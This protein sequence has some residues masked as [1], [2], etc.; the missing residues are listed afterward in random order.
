MPGADD[1][2]LI[3]LRTGELARFRRVDRTRWVNGRIVSVSG[4]G[5]ILLRDSDGSARSI[6]LADLEVRRPDHRGRL[7]WMNGSLLPETSVQL[8]LFD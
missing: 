7:T 4:D 3:G 8:D 1:L 6:R 5:S 2:A